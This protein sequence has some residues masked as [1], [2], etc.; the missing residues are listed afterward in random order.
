MF[1]IKR[2]GSKCEFLA[3]KTNKRD[4]PEVVFFKFP[5]K[6]VDICKQWVVNSANVR[7]ADLC[8]ARL[9]Y[10]TVCD[11]HFTRECFTSDTKTTL[12]KSAVPTRRSLAQPLLPT[13]SVDTLTLQ[14]TSLSTKFSE[15]IYQFNQI[16][17][18]I[19]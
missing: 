13:P 10:R 7:I 14:P 19:K 18:R 15:V 17:A 11:R 3:C 4:N 6:R 2:I 5:V 1:G 8:A 9:Q 16:C 12:T